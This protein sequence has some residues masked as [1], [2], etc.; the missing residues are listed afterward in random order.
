MSCTC[1]VTNRCARAW[2]L[3][4]VH[5]ALIPLASAAAEHLRGQVLQTLR[6]HLQAAKLDYYHH[7]ST[8]IPLWNVHHF[9]D[10]RSVPHVE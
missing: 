10:P 5:Q 9:T 3:R 6:W 8:R 4:D 7:G 2:D 1:S